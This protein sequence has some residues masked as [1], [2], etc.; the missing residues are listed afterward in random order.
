MPPKVPPKITTK[1]STC[2]CG[3]VA[4]SVTGQDKGAVAC[5]CNNCQKWSGSA[6]AHNYRYLKADMK[7]SKGEDLLKGFADSNTKTGNVLTRWFCQEC[8]S[9]PVFLPKSAETAT[10][11]QRCGFASLLMPG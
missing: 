6:F 2:L 5:H 8:V 11:R 7:V 10:G 1:T 4:L 9:P 3:G